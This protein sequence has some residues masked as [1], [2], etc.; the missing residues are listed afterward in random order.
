MKISEEQKKQNQY[1]CG[2][3]AFCF[4]YLF[5][6]DLKVLPLIY[7]KLK[8]RIGKRLVASLKTK[9][10]KIILSTIFSIFEET[11]YY[12]RGVFLGFYFRF[13]ENFYVSSNG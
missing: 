9:S 12:V 6:G 10:A 5:K 13:F 3:I 11:F 8:R 2:F 4:Y 7:A 1:A